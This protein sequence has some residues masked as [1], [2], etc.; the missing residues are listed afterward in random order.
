MVTPAARREAVAY[1]APKPFCR[2]HVTRVTDPETGLPTF[3]AA[4]LACER[5]RRAR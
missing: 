3:P 1:L 2:A 4:P 5:G